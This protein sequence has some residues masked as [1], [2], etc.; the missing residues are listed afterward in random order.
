VIAVEIDPVK[1]QVLANMLGVACVEFQDVRPFHLGSSVVLVGDVRDPSWFHV[2]LQLP[3]KLILWSAPCVTWSQG[4]RL[5]GLRDVNGLLLLDA[6]GVCG[7]FDPKASVGENV[8]GLLDHP[9]WFL[10]QLFVRT[11][12]GHTFQVRK[13][14][15]NNLVRMTRTRVFLL[16]GP[17][18][19]ELPQVKVDIWV[20]RR[21]C[22]IMMTKSSTVNSQMRSVIFCQGVSFCRPP[23]AFWRLS[24]FRLGSFFNC[25]LFRVA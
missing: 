4:G 5:K 3:A 24:I 22:W 6:I 1:A 10:V 7:V 11:L 19:V 20:F 23:F 21:G 25:G 12:L 14:C 2:S 13:A 17:H 15:L 18:V 9:D 8:A 16:L